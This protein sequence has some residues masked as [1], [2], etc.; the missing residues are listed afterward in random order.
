MSRNEQPG[1]PGDVDGDAAHEA[2][3]RGRIVGTIVTAVVVTIGLCALVGL[4]LHMREGAIRPALRF[5]EQ[6]LSAPGQVAGVRQELFRTANPRPTSK[7]RDRAEL[8]RFL[9]VDRQRGIV[10]I[11]IDDAIEIAARRAAG[12]GGTP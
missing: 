1:G 10:Q 11:P 9:W 8:Q 3:P 7:E 5:P 4:L 2:L 12:D 6:A